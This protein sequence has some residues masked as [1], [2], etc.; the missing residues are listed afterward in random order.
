[1]LWIAAHEVLFHLEI[2]SVPEAFKVSGD[3]N[4]PSGGGEQV[5]QKGKFPAGDGGGLQ[6]AEH[7]LKPNGQYGRVTVGIG[8][9]NPGSAGNRDMCGGQPVEGG[10]LAPG[11]KR[12][13]RIL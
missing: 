6:S 2:G 11:K 8:D 10:L 1:M 5:Q 4:R 12:K 9:G 13:Q 7:L 3:L